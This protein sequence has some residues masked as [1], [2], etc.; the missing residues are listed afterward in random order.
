MA[1][2]DWLSVNCNGVWNHSKLY[3]EKRLKITTRVFNSVVEIWHKN[4]L[5]FTLLYDPA[6]AIFEKDLVQIKVANKWLYSPGL[7]N[8][9]TEFLNVHC[10][11]F[12]SFSRL[13][14]CKDFN[15]FYNKLH[16][17]TLI[18]KVASSKIL[19]KGQSKFSFHAVNR[20]G[21]EF[22]YMRIGT[23]NSEIRAYLY[24]KTVEM[25]EVKIKPYIIDLWNVNGLDMSK[26]IWRLEFAIK[27]DSWHL[28]S[29]TTGEDIK[30]NL[31]II[32][33]ASILESIYLHCVDNLFTFYKNQK[34][35]KL[36]RN[37][38]IVLFE[39]NQS[40]WV[41][42]KYSSFIDST[43]S[44]KILINKLLSSY[45]ELRVHYY[46]HAEQYYNV[47][48][49]HADEHGLYDYFRKRCDARNIDN[50]F[51]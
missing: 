38:K 49:S 35:D 24:N 42:I 8:M 17:E 28:I 2:I 39:P 16:P 44:D 3:T 36:N 20:N 1:I 50:P 19:H 47:A 48:K 18:K 43:K 10:L 12:K 45:D 34:K 6:S 14:L 5:L 9:L 40:S 33:D 23:M 51:T 11:V 27:G 46:E 30:H 31:E 25:N 41:L 37:E 21:C 15:L 7:Y 13:D 26:D 4:D 32:K 22:Q 29:K